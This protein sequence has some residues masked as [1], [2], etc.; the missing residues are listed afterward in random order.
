MIREILPQNSKISLSSAN[1]LLV[2]ANLIMLISFFVIQILVTATLGTKSQEID[3][4]RTEKDKLRQQN[5]ILTSQ[6]NEAKTI[7]STKEIQEKYNLQEKGVNF[8]ENP[9]QSIIASN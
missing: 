2:R 4:I 6:I 7:A 1:S 9:D 3:S 5:N 8:L